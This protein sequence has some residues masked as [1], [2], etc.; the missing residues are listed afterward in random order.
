[1]DAIGSRHDEAAAVED[2][3]SMHARNPLVKDTPTA[4]KKQHQSGQRS[5]L[6][7]PKCWSTNP[8][9]NTGAR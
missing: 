9:A 5:A 1:M 6:G 4:K 3:I 8:E 2:G 7:P